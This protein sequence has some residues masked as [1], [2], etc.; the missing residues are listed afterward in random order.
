MTA[1]NLR[2]DRETL[3]AA[4]RT[5]TGLSDFGDTWFFEPMDRYIEAANAQSK[6]TEA[7]FGGQTEAIVKGLAARLRM[8][9]D[10]RRHPE[11]LDEQ[12]EV[13][14]II[15]GLPRTGSTIFHRLL[16][17]APGMTAIRW[18]EA[19]NYAPLPGDE[20]GNPKARR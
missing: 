7:G 4:A 18:Y 2:F 12:V 5:R 15:L 19:Q 9:E 11:I 8:V 16:A 13:A 14:A 17:S 20:P 6:L 3:L 10:I 1:A